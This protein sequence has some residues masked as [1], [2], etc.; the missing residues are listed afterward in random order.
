MFG[1]YFNMFTIYGT[2]YNSSITFGTTSKFHT[3]KQ[4]S[5]ES[6]KLQKIETI[7]KIYEKVL[8][9]F[10]S[11][12]G[13][14]QKK[15]KS[16]YPDLVAGEKIKGFLFN[17]VLPDGNRLQVSRL[18]TRQDSDELLTFGILNSGNDTIERYRVSKTGDVLVM[19]KKDAG[20]CK[21]IEPNFRY[22]DKSLKEFQNLGLYSDN[23]VL[24]NKKLHGTEQNTSVSEIL[25][26]INNLNNS[27][28]LEPE[29]Q[30]VCSQ[31][32]KLYDALALKNCK[33]AFLFKKMFLGDDTSP[34]SKSLLFKKLFNNKNYA[35]CN[36]KSNSDN[37]VFKVIESGQNGEISNVFLFFK[38]GKIAK[39]KDKYKDKAVYR[40]NEFVFLNDKE[41]WE[42]QLPEIL[43]NLGAKLEE[44]SSFIARQYSKPCSLNTELKSVDKPAP[45]ETKQTVTPQNT[46]QV[47]N[48]QK[49]LLHQKK[50]IKKEARHLSDSSG[51]LKTVL[52]NVD[53]VLKYNELSISSVTAQLYDLFQTPVENRSPHLIHEKLSN[54]KIF[55]GRFS[56]LASDGANIT[57]TKVK[58]PR[59]VDFVY[60]SIKINKNNNE[61]VINIDPEN[62][63]IL[64]STKDG[65]VI[66][67]KRQFVKHIS[68]KEFLEQQPLALNLPEYFNEIFDYRADCE[69]IFINSD[70]KIR[71]Q[72]KPTPEEEILDLLRQ[73]DSADLY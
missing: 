36:I 9:Y 67:D 63:R 60:F 49:D 41:I 4:F 27:L 43:R 50:E 68:K 73:Y 54:G 31:A 33:K 24:L 37:R 57:V 13:I 12:N 28:G 61:F 52:I 47:K 14:Y 10:N 42:L 55:P 2:K 26:N 1:F 22:L 51:D 5:L 19:K 71:K 16:L 11:L 29:I 69:R 3:V 40:S 17:S 38:D 72:I 6:T 45:V 18:N 35:F 23:F 66:I 59:Y 56:I 32:S 8:K 62:G 48:R 44:F 20:D 21:F 53:P 39:V 15:F 70:L 30:T 64:E 34:K 46:P 25:N 58:S 7:S 65:K